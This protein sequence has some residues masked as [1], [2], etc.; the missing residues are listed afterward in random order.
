M[1]IKNNIKC[2]TECLDED[3]LYYVVVNLVG[4]VGNE[5]EFYAAVELDFACNVTIIQDC[6]DVEDCECISRE[7]TACS[8]Y[9]IG[10]FGPFDNCCEVI[11]D[12]VVANILD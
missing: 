1:S 10:Y 7:E 12:P 4:N 3:E 5:V 8:P 9:N 2:T 11:P 6:A